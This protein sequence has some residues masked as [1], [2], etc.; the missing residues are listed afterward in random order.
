MTETVSPLAGKAAIVTGAGAGIGRA[1]AQ[2]FAAAGARVACLDLDGER[3]A[4]TARACDGLA[5]EAD[6][7]R[8]TMVVAA[9]ARVADAFGRLDIL[10]NDAAATDPAG[11]VVDLTVED[12]DRVVGVNLRGAFLM[13]KYAIPLMARSGGGSIIHIASQ[14]GHVGAP[15]RAVYCATKGA[16]I[17]L[18]KAM[19]IDHAAENIRVNT[20]SPGAVETG[21]LLLRFPDMAA[22][23]RGLGAKHVLDRLGLPEEIAAAA[24][25]LAGPGSSFMTGADLLV[26]GGYT[27]T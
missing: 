14:L 15:D 5:V 25:F 24:V 16:L 20:L 21:R 6:V 4:A 2:A 7:S 12:W 19:A 8:E 3:A 23:R 13:S 18:A 22:A 9:V 11:S 17:Q 27:A 10:V 26:D 1:I